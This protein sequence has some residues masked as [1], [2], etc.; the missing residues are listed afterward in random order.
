MPER[1]ERD[2]LAPEGGTL[3]TRKERIIYGPV[4]S[5]HYA[6]LFDDPDSLGTGVAAFLGRA[7]DDGDKLLV[8]STP[9]HWQLT[10]RS[11]E[12]GGY[13]LSAMAEH[14]RIV[15]RD[16]AA[17]LESAT[18]GG[19]PD[20]AAF[21][22]SVGDLVREMSASARVSVYGELVELLAMDGDFDSVMHLEALWNELA[23]RCSFRVMCGYSS[24]H[25]AA[26][27]GETRLRTVC[28]AHAQVHTSIGDPLGSWLLKAARLPFRQAPLPARG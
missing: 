8:I 2:I 22:Q 1:D 19:V 3:V 6:Q 12:H 7:Y 9:R 17:L 21:D 13:D 28:D 25:F 18:H 26:L 27:G 20:A 23:A 5:E 24:G 11:L 10:A 15:I 4:S 16:A 14:G